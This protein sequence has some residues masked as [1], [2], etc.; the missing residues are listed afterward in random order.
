M[1]IKHVT[2]LGFYRK[3]GQMETLFSDTNVFFDES[4]KVDYQAS[5]VPVSTLDSGNTWTLSTFVSAVS[6]DL[7]LMLASGHLFVTAPDAESGYAV[8]CYAPVNEPEMSRGGILLKRQGAH[9]E[10]VL[11]H[12]NGVDYLVDLKGCGSPIGGFP[13]AHYRVQSGCPSGYHVRVTGALNL[14]EAHDEF[15][16]LT[17][18]S[19]GQ[20]EKALA[21]RVLP[22][23]YLPTQNGQ[24]LLMRLVPSSFRLS[25][26]NHPQ[27]DA[28]KPF[29]LS[30]FSQNSGR[31][32]AFLLA[33]NPPI[34]HHNVSTQNLVFVSKGLYTLTDFSEAGPVYQPHDNLDVPFAFY[35][36]FFSRRKVDPIAYKFFLKGL[37]RK[38]ASIES[39]NQEIISEKIA[40]A[41]VRQRLDSIFDVS[42]L[43]HNLALVRSFMPAS[44]F[45]GDLKR[46]AQEEFLPLFAHKERLLLYYELILERHGLDVLGQLWKQTC[47][48]FELQAHFEKEIKLRVPKIRNPVISSSELGSYCTQD[49]LE[50]RFCAVPAHPGE[51]YEAMQ[52]I[53]D[54]EAGIDTF[55]E[56]G[57]IEIPKEYTSPV[58]MDHWMAL[59]GCATSYLFPFMPFLLVH[60]F[61]ETRFIEAVLTMPRDAFSG[62]E[63]TT[64][65]HYRTLLLHHEHLLRTDPMQYYALLCESDDRLLAEVRI[66]PV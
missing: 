46:W 3:K 16:L 43:K 52:W 37:G 13:T 40:P 26:I 58:W 21:D 44:Y 57:E 53:R 61:N 34:K 15:S 19:L 59:Q 7:K 36:Y 31:E 5:I 17:A 11:A 24:S 10:P 42:A 4:I 47:P 51:L 60:F 25:Y 38:A 20:T 56:S 49:T 54:I 6:E 23:G 45:S 63:L 28:L 35:P 12:V 55:L 66:F 64:L 39:L 62:K 41:V 29:S 27:L 22:L 18:L 65:A 30:V 2:I 1:S 48:D 50:T 9:Y 33:Q 32:T 8:L 14:D